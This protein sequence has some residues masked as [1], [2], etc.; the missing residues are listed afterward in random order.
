M[1]F[2]FYTPLTKTS[3]KHLIAETQSKLIVKN[4]LVKT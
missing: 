3:G 1:D 4:V 2:I